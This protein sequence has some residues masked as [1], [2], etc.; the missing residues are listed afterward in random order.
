MGL[1]PPGSPETRGKREGYAGHLYGRFEPPGGPPDAPPDRADPFAYRE[2]PWE[3]GGGG[4]G[5]IAPPSGHYLLLNAGVP[6]STAQAPL[7][8]SATAWM[9]PGGNGRF[10]VQEESSLVQKLQRL[11]S[12]SLT[13]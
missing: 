6:P 13:G 8:N 10:G 5:P 11:T 4:G 1:P 2:E 9:Q 7:P 3:P 12:S